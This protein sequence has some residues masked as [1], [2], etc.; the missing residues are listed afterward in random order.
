LS[1]YYHVNV[2]VTDASTK[3]FE[4]TIGLYVKPVQLD[5]SGEFK[6]PIRAGFP[7]EFEANLK[8]ISGFSQPIDPKETIKDE[9]AYT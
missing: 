8:G 4:K 6:S 9:Y 5:C 7:L 1:S 3:S 2:Q